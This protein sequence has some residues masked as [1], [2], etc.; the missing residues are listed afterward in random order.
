MIL[1]VVSIIVFV[2]SILGLTV[3]I[4]LWTYKDAQVKSTQDPVFWL[5]VVLLMQGIGIILYM[6]VGRTKNVP[7]PGTYKKALITCIVVSVLATAGFITTTV[8]FARGDIDFGNSTWN[9]GVWGMH[10]S[11]V[12]ND[13]W[14]TD[15]RRGRGSS[16]ISRN[17]DAAQMHNFHVESI[18][19][20][21]S[22]YLFLQQG[23]MSSRIDI[24]GDFYGR[25]NLHDYGFSPGRIRM[26]LQ[27]E[28]ID[29]AYTII[30]WRVE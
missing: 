17:L 21:D 16:R 9:S 1:F 23:N 4:A 20:G 10:V 8:M 25:I 27:F 28:R 24:S 13:E 30:S 19:E 18:N 5:L 22:L 15:V 11:N 2:L 7:A 14:T 12:R 26:T 6:C 3:F 29:R